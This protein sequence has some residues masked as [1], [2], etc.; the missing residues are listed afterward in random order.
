MGM[1]PLVAGASDTQPPKVGTAGWAVPRAVAADFPAQGSTLERYAARFDAVEINTATPPEFRFALKAPRTITHD[2]RLVNV[3]SLLTAF[4]DEA[5]DLGEKLGPV[6]VQLPPGLAY[7]AAVAE[8]FFRELRGLWPT[9]IV[10]EP[11]HP[12]WFEA[13]ADA[14]LIASRVGRVAADPPRHPAA[15]APGGWKGIS[16]WRMHGSPRMY[17]SSYEQAALVALAADVVAAAGEIWCVFDN[18]ASGAAAA[19]ALG[20]REMTAA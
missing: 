14:L 20:L 15:A 17:Y 2:A 13:G 10:C 5:L 19:N 6:L 18:T 12:S 4:R 9:S 11:R 8:P 1:Q 3:T 16:Y 7:D